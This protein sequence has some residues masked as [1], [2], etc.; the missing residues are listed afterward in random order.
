MNKPILL[1]DLDECIFPYTV[2]YIPWLKQYQG[3]I[4]AFPDPKGEP[5]HFDNEPWHAELD[6][7]FINHPIT[8]SIKPRP[9]ALYAVRAL[10]KKYS[11]TIC[12]ARVRATH[13]GAT[14]AWVRKHLPYFGETIFTSIGFAKPGVSKGEVV[15]EKGAIGLIDDRNEHLDSLF[16]GYNGYLVDR[17]NPIP[18]DRGAKSWQEITTSLLSLS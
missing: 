3:I 11:L 9:E 5:D 14:Q 16:P 2:N 6:T 15:R 12:T 7:T 17:V 13:E 4:K 8:L 1:I 18:S 10:S